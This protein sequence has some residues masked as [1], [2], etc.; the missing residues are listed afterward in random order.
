M[1]LDKVSYSCE[2]QLASVV[3]DI[4]HN[5]DQ[6]KQIDLIFLDF[7]KAFDT[8][9]HHRLLLKLS[10]YGIQSK[11][12]CWI[13]SWLTQRIQRVAVNGTC[14]TWLSVKSAL[15]QGTVLEPLLFLL[16]IND[17]AKD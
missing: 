8:V 9:P 17:I 10:S 13:K 14:S 6:Q 4:S 7:C 12:H 1:V 15:R 3:E 16:H 2:A 5:L 11:P